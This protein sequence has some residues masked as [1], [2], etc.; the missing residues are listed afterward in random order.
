[1]LYGVVCYGTMFMKGV[2]GMKLYYA[3]TYMASRV[4][5]SLNGLFDLELDKKYYQP[6]ELNKKL[7][8]ISG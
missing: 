8:K 1:M 2:A 5:A 3:A 4:C 6:K 7:K